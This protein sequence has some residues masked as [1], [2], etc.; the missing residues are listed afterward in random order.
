MTLC[1]YPK[2]CHLTPSVFGEILYENFLFDVPK[3]FDLCVLYGAGNKQLVTKMVDNIFTQQPKYNDDLAQSID[4]LAQVW[5]KVM[6]YCKNETV[7]VD[8]Q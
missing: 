6:T 4:T 2:E 7:T 3:L 8:F 5:L 1:S